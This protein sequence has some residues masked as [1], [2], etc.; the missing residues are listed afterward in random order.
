MESR[1]SKRIVEVESKETNTWHGFYSNDNSIEF[2]K[3]GTVHA[4][5]ALGVVARANRVA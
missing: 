2:R 3:H 4:K 1:I 5:A